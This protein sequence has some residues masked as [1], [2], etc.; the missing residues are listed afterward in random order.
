MWQAKWH[1]QADCA[2]FGAFLA[3]DSG[4]WFRIGTKSSKQK[5]IFNEPLAAQTIFAQ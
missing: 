4:V 2:S 3:Y 1:L 5:A